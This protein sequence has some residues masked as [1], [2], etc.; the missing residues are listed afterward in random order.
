VKKIALLGS[1]GSIGQSTLSL[2]ESHPDRFVPVALAG[3]AN[4]EALLVQCQRWRPQV[5]SIATD[6]LAASLTVRLKAAGITGIEVVYG[7]AGTVRVATHPTPPCSPANRSASPT[8]N[9]S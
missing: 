2:C 6:E 9:A 8:R 4:L 3:G 7:T 1:T 5:V